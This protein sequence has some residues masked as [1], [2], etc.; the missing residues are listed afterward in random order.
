MTGADGSV[1]ETWNYLKQNGVH[2][3]LQIWPRPTAT[4]CKII[5]VYAVFEAALQL[6][7]PAKTVYGPISPTGHQ[8]VYKVNTP[9][10]SLQIHAFTCQILT[11]LHFTDQSPFSILQANGVA[12]Y[13]VTLITYTAL[14]W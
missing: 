8:P 12:A 9:H 3:F 13:L 10:T 1:T 11:L 4:A 7:L 2:G 5:V 6:L 14:W